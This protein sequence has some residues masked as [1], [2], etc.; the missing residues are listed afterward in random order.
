M[1]IFDQ[2]QPFWNQKPHENRFLIKIEWKSKN[3]LERVDIFH[4]SYV[5]NVDIS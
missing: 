1:L 5:K 2:K 4:N 3:I